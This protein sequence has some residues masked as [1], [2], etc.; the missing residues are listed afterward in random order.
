MNSRK[1]IHTIVSLTLALILL[2]AFSG[3]A[4]SIKD[5]MVARI[6]AINALKDKGIVGE[7][8]KGF[9]EFRGKDQPQKEMVQDENKDRSAVYGAIAKKQGVD[10]TLVGQRR[11]KQIA[12]IGSPGHWFQDAKGKWYKK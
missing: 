6:P 1:H 5:R 11:A 2:A 4:A 8:N 9:L 7:N 10:A 3:H 12:D